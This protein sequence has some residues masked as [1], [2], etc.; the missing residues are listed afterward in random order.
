MSEGRAMFTQMVDARAK[1]QWFLALACAAEIAGDDPKRCIALAKQMR[2]VRELVAQ[3]ADQAQQNGLVGVADSGI[4]QNNL[5][6]G[7][8]LSDAERQPTQVA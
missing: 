6:N 8:L 3:L 2:I 1:K 5:F 7:E 4:S